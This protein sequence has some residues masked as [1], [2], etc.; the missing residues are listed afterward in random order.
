[1]S[2]TYQAV[3]DAIRSRFHFDASQL[4][5]RIANMFDISWQK[6]QVATEWIRAANQAQAAAKEQMR[7]SVLYRPRIQQL[8]TGQWRAYYLPGQMPHGALRKGV[9]AFGATP[10]E[11]CA[12]FDKVWN[13]E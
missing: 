8:I 1:M 11:A 7:P 10:A 13:G 3:Y 5:D 6:E 12:N 4:I 9:E 2:D